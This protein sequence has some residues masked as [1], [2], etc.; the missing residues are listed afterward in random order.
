MLQYIDTITL[1]PHKVFPGY[2]DCMSPILAIHERTES[3][4][5]INN[6]VMCWAG[7]PILFQLIPKQ[8]VARWTTKRD[9]IKGDV[10]CER[11]TIKET[12][13]PYGLTYRGVEVISTI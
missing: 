13:K 1:I 10:V 3:C 8:L 2:L 11:T 4:T 9:K 5:N 12:D 6:P 7:Y